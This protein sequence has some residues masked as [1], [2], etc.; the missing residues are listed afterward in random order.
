M[1]TNKINYSLEYIEQLKAEKEAEIAKSK[2]RMAQLSRAIMA[3]PPTSNNV[4]LWMHYASNG[5][6]AYRGLITCVKFYKRLKSTFTRN[7]KS[8]GFFS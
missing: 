6:I 3:P 4:E 1:N 8:K 5:M 7:K 2:E